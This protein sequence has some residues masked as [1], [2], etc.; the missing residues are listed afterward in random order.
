MA[1]AVNGDGDGD[2]DAVIADRAGPGGTG[3]VEADPEAPSAAFAGLVGSHPR[4]STRA[5]VA[6]VVVG[7]R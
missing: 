4:A 3:V 2:G 1:V 5:S 6:M 7:L